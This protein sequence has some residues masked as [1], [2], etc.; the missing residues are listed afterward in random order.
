[1]VQK[2]KH[3]KTNYCITKFRIFQVSLKLLLNMVKVK[4]YGK[5]S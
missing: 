4:I 5:I 1:M 3:K 2:T